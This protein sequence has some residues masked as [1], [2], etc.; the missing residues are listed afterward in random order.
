MHTTYQLA[1]VHLY[2]WTKGDNCRAMG[3][4]YCLQLRDCFIF[5]ANQLQKTSTPSNASCQMLLAKI[6]NPNDCTCFLHLYKIPQYLWDQ[7]DKTAISETWF[8]NIIFVWMFIIFQNK[9]LSSCFIL[10]NVTVKLITY[11]NYHYNQHLNK[12][13]MKWLDYNVT[14][15]INPFI[16]SFSENLLLISKNVF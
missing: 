1:V 12:W 4:F 11:N 16:S 6:L 14:N 5:T 15:N 8:S 3:L 2:N 9:N 13:S 10:F 7:S